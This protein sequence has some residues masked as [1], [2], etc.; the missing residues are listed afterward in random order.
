MIYR[1]NL[2]RILVINYSDQV[3]GPTIMSNYSDYPLV[4]KPGLLENGEFLDETP[5]K[6]S[7]CRGDF[8]LLCLIT[9]G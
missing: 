4:I 6:T 3:Y 5:I 7:I 8:P 2:H 9:G 1:G